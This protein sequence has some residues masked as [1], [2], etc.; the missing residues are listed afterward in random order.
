MGALFIF[1][2]MATKDT[3]REK[4]VHHGRN[5][6][7]I[8]ELKQVKQ[9]TLAQRL[10]KDWSQG[11]I[12]QLESTEVIGADILEQVAKALEVAPEWLERLTEESVNQYFN[13]FSGE[14]YHAFSSGPSINQPSPHSINQPKDCTINPLDKC[15][16]LLEKNEK[17]YQE[18]LKVE[19][20][21]NALLERLLGQKG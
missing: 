14:H 20:E 7:R 18:L 21:K 2:S 16:E 9:D 6:Q 11:R 12:S 15:F 4:A 8:R 5:I 19:R 17:L 1:V 13:T 10:G 3:P